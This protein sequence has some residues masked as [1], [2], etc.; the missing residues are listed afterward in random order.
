[1]KPNEAPTVKAKRSPVILVVG[2]GAALVR[3]CNDLVTPMQ[4]TVAGVE[5]GAESAFA[6]QKLPMAVVMRKDAVS[7]SPRASIARE[8]GIELI[9]LSGDDV[10]DVELKVLLEGALNAAQNR[11]RRGS[12]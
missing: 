1:M 5:S 11:A 4:A 8:L 12:R 10:D 3:R 7:S 9:A 6:M 2:F